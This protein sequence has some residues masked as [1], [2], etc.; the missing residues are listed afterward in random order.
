MMQT[1]L[2]HAIKKAGP[3]VRPPSMLHLQVEVDGASNKHLEVREKVRDACARPP[4][5]SFSLVCTE[6][7]G[8]SQAPHPKV[9]SLHHNIAEHLKVTMTLSLRGGCFDRAVRQEANITITSENHTQIVNSSYVNACNSASPYTPT[10]YSFDY[11]NTGLVVPS[12]TIFATKD[13]EHEKKDKNVYAP[14]R[15]PKDPTWDVDVSFKLPES[16]H[17][18]LRRVSQGT[19]LTNTS[20]ERVARSDK[21]AVVVPAAKPDPRANRKRKMWPCEPDA[22][23]GDQ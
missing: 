1:P 2:S 7:Y 22:E 13:S 17:D 23:N 18:A 3:C 10:P 20:E 8:E 16:L 4:K 15:K 14:V 12:A 5:P 6:E 9:E 21:A 19:D 11:S